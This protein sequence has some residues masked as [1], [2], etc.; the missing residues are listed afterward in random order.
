M[1][2]VVLVV[3][4]ALGSLTAFA[5]APAIVNNDTKVATVQDDYKEIAASEVPQA[6]QEA[7]QADYPGA[8]IT[9][10]YVNEENTYKI[11]VKVGDQTG[12]LFANESGEWVEQQ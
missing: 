4:M 8:E 1:K 5:A 9:K 10:A 12:T 2:K 6:V 11:E 3:A 7:L